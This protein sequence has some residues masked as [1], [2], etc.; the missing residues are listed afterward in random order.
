MTAREI[1]DIPDARVHS[2]EDNLVLDVTAACGA[3]LMSDIMAFVKDRVVLL[4]TRH[5]VFLACGRL[6]EAGL[7]S[8]GSRETR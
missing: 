1:I 2:G 3:D 5:S 7:K 8:G 4:S 6:C